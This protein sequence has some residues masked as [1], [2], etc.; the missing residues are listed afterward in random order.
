MENADGFWS[1]SSS[2]RKPGM[3]QQGV[4]IHPTF[5][6]LV[7]DTSTSRW[8]AEED[9]AARCSR[10]CLRLAAVRCSLAAAAGTV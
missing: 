8:Q 2:P 1:S 3:Q 6:S 4:Q 5:I 9:Q 7:F 10:C